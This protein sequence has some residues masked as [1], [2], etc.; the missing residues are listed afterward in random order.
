MKKATIADVAE[1]AGVSKATVSRFL[2]QENV[3]EEIAERIRAAIQ[4]TGYVARGSKANKTNEKTTE[5]KG[6]KSKTNVKAKQRNYRFG[7]LVKDITLPRTRNIIQ[8]L[9]DVLREQNIT[10][11]ICITDG[12]EELEEKYLTSYIVQNVNG[13]LVES[14]SSTEFIQKQMR[15]TSIPVLFLHEKKEQLNS[16]C[17]H[18]VQA[19]EVLGAY[20]LK[21]EQLIVRYLGTEQELAEQRLQGI[22]NAYHEKR[23]PIDLKLCLCDGSYGDIYEK[24]KEAFTEKFDLLLLERDEM[25]VPLTKFAREYHIAIPQNTS[26][27]SFGGHELCTVMSPTLTALVYDYAA[28]ASDIV[29]HMN[30]L[31]EKT[32]V[33]EQTEVFSVREGESV[34]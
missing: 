33:K 16:C 13:I 19:G 10:F 20:M 12:G 22:R 25:A 32:A 6:E 23:Q 4:E 7:M 11:S 17:F 9:K 18:E 21:K 15:T 28:Y 30:A 5:P 34:R 31:I 3:R 8:A 29:Q 14:C 27:I 2:K 1:L 24:I 26:V